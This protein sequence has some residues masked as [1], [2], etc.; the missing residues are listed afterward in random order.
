MDEATS[1]LDNETESEIMNDIME[2]FHHKK[3]LIISTH[4]KEILRFADK[5]IDINKIKNKNE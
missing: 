1:A 5:I 3:T 4:K 2:N